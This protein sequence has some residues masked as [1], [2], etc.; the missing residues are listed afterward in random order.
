MMLMHPSSLS[1][2]MGNAKSK[3]PEDLSVGAQTYC[4]QLAKEFVYNYR[5]EISSKYLDK[6]KICEDEAIKLY[7]DVF[8]TNYKKNTL[9][10]SNKWLTGEIDILGN[11]KIIDIKNAWSLTTFPAFKEDA[12]KLE[13]EW[14]GRGYMMLWDVDA[15]EIAYCLV[16]TPAELIGWEDE[17]AHYVDHIDPDLRVTRVQYE[18]DKYTEEL[19]KIKC[20]S[21][22]KFINQ[23][24]T[25][26]A[27]HHQDFAA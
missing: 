18:R 21:A 1:N 16:S 15:F 4:K 24:I 19:I 14:Q 12:H 27:E 10:K 20:E 2:I 25:A 23:C 5:A 11:N 22:Q 3:K 7:N 26:I 6:G 13:Y 9:R 8:F 17:A